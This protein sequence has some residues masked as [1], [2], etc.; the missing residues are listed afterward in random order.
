MK[1]KTIAN[2]AAHSLPIPNYV[3]EEVV[4]SPFSPH[5]L[6]DQV[7][8]QMSVAA[9]VALHGCWLDPLPHPRL[10]VH[11]VSCHG[12]SSCRRADSASSAASASQSLSSCLFGRNLLLRGLEVVSPLDGEGLH[13]FLLRFFP[14]RTR[15]GWSSASRASSPVLRLCHSTPRFFLGPGGNALCRRLCEEFLVQGTRRSHPSRPCLP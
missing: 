6:P 5:V 7:A 10:P 13:L 9:P 12:A 1:T 14:A 4:L 15:A 3:L 2:T 8:A 11:D